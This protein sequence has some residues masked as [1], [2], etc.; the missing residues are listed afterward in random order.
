MRSRDARR[1]CRALVVWVVWVA[2]FTGCSEGPAPEAPRAEQEGALLVYV[3]SWPLET[4]ARRIGGEHVDV[5][6][7]APE[8]VDPAYWSPPPE[9]VA[10][11]QSADLIVENGAGFAAWTAH[12]T[13]PGDRRLDTSAGLGEHLLAAS[14][15]VTHGHGPEGEHTHAVTDFNTWLDPR[16]ARRQARAIGEALAARRPDAAADFD[17]RLEALAT[18]L[19]ALDRRLAAALAPLAGRPVLFSH[20]VY[21][22][23]ARR[24]QL[25]GRSLHWEPGEMP[26]DAEWRRLEGLLAEEPARWMFFE[27]EPHPDAEARLAALG[28]RVIVFAPGG[29]RSAQEADWLDLMAANAERIEAAAPVDP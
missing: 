10:D 1:A 16:L 25:S 21:A 2:A 18:E 28:V 24:Y 20:P 14:D 3:V 17:T 9:I 22:Y 12:A 13:L 6:F 29:A 8:G 19:D 27:G 4:F 15:G 11:F 5:V 23:M 26:D 7:P